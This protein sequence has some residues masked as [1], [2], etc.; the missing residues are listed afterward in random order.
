MFSSSSTPSNRRRINADGSVN[1]FCQTCGEFIG[2]SSVHIV[3]AQCEM[4]GRVEEGHPLNEE[5]VRL[6]QQGKMRA[7]SVTM[8]TLS[9]ELNSPKKRKFRVSDMTGNF[10][11]AVGLKKKAKA[12][13]DSVKASKNV[14]KGRLFEGTGLGNIEAVDEQ[15][16]RDKKKP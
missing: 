7:E 3:K 9:Q 1:V 11:E 16:N 10:L 4:C 2:K 6:Y 12:E 15:L 13:P 14:K 5:A 8:L